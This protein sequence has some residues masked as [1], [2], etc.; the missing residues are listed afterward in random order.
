MNVLIVRLSAVGDVIHG[1][2]VACALRDAF[3]EAHLSWLVEERAAALLQG[4]P[5]LDE[6]ITVP[7]GWLKSPSTVWRLR[8]RLRALAPDVTIDIQGLSK[9]A[10]AAWLS[11]ARRRIGFD[12]A[13]GRELSRW[14]NTELVAPGGVHVID[15]NLELLKPLGIPSPQVRFDVPVDPAA[16][17]AADRMIRRLGLDGG[18]A[19]MSPGAGWVSKLWPPKRFAEVAAHLVHAWQ[20][21]T[22]VAW[23]GKKEQAMAHELVAASEGYAWQA[24]PTSLPELAALARRARI[25]VASDTGPLHLAAA[26]G[27]P[28]VGLFGPMPAERNGPYGAQHV[29]VQAVRFEGT[30]RQRRNAPADVM[31][32]ITVEMVAE[33]CDT[34]LRRA[35]ARAA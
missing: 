28:C 26:V 24:P 11:G 14:L 18:F 31:E 1:M 9:S 8:K 19:L 10:I 2:P 13:N 35:A 16:K 34:I 7:R 12:G 27:T 21:P 33:A 30:S 4:H 3:P 5:A 17:A 23:G 29:A 6:L 15:C 20:L 32:A 25:F 22:I